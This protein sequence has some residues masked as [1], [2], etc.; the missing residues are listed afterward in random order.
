MGQLVRI[1][2]GRAVRR[3][4]DHRERPGPARGGPSDPCTTLPSAWR[5]HYGSY[6]ACV[7]EVLR[8]A[9]CFTPAGHAGKAPRSCSV[10]R[11]VFSNSRGSEPQGEPRLEEQSKRS[12][13][14]H[15]PR[16]LAGQSEFGP[17]RQ[18]Q[19]TSIARSTFWCFGIVGS[20]SRIGVGIEVTNPPRVVRTA[21][22]R[23]IRPD[24]GRHSAL[25]RALYIS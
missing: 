12:F 15:Q 8:L 18:P 10:S 11:R 23:R 1:A 13:T 21:V 16:I 7:L 24:V 14:V 25:G 22:R 3:E 4:L 17:G 5:Q 19:G 6:P 9:D 20:P 2:N